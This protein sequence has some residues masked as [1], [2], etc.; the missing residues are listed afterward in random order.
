MLEVFKKQ[1]TDE[2]RCQ[3][4]GRGLSTGAIAE[5]VTCFVQSLHYQ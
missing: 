4:C 2:Y 3:V 1:R 5:D